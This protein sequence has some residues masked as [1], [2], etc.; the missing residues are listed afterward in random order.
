MLMKHILCFIMGYL[1]PM[2]TYVTLSLSMHF[3]C[4]VHGIGAI[5]VCANF[6]INWYKIAQIDEFRKHATI[7]CFI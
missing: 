4:K 1:V 3:F 7:V 5:N 6:G 2:E